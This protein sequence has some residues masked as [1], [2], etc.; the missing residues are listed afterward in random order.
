M[1]WKPEY[2]LL[3]LAS[4]ALQFTCSL[5]IEK[6]RLRSP[7]TAKRWMWFGL[8]SDLGL[9][10]FFK[11]LDF[12]L[13][14]V[15]TFSDWMGWEMHTSSV[16]LLLPVGISFYV[17]QTMSYTLDV[18]RGQL[19]AEQDF[20]YFALYVSFFPQLVAGP[21]ERASALL[22]QFKK[23]PLVTYLRISSGLK[24]MATGLFKK[25]VLADN[26]APFVERIYH[27]LY[28]GSGL[29]YVLATW[30]FMFQVYGDFSGYSDIA[31]GSARLMGYDLMQ[32]FRQPFMATHVA[33]FWNRWHISL[34]SWVKDYLYIPLGG[35]RKGELRTYVNLFLAMFIIGIWHGAKWTVVVYA[36]IN[37]L[38]V[39]LS[40]YWQKNPIAWN[41]LPAG[42]LQRNWHRF[43]TFQIICLPH[44]FFRSEY[45]SQAWSILGTM[46]QDTAQGRLF[47]WPSSL[48]IIGSAALLWVLLQDYWIEK[49][50]ASFSS[51]ALHSL[52]WT[53]VVLAIV[54]F[55]NF[56]AAQ[57][58]YFQF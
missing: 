5:Y 43:L 30:A 7:D 52:Y 46:A 57:F 49:K 15:Q 10:F 28:E 14:N 22:P 50:Y 36:I 31:I 56:K 54:V 26:L 48:P 53:L 40:R 17:F 19:K 47:H 38:S 11:Y 4:T 20:L 51:P 12:A 2:G 37:G 3:L 29:E 32:N 23:A 16:N 45:V 21:I 44:V 1:S 25:M 35:N 27:P 39:A 41:I 55:G 9:L 18:Y 34:S 42:S 58:I 13:V 8:A 6:Y 33:E 24:L